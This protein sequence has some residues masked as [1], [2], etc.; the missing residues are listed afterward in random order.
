M[1]VVVA[2]VAVLAFAATVL[3]LTGAGRRIQRSPARTVME[4]FGDEW[5]TVSQVASLLEVPEDD[6]V[7][8]VER[9]AIPFY[10]IAG[11]SRTHPAD[12]RFRRDE[13][14]AWTIG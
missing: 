11:G 7:G 12:Y 13:I 14:D 2:G 4:P 9:D 10:V 6:V 5:L 3:V 1:D 8:L